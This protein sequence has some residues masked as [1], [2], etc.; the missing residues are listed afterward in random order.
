MLAKHSKLV[1]SFIFADIS[2][3]FFN[4]LLCFDLLC[5]QKLVHI[6]SIIS[7]FNLKDFYF[8][9]MAVFVNGE[10]PKH[11]SDLSQTITYICQV[12]LSEI[13]VHRIVSSV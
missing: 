11:R 2:F 3:L 9:F 5:N 7:N 1:S 4:N 13:P 6:R 10:R 8:H 12:I